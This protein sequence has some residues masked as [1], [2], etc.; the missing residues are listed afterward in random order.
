MPLPRSSSGWKKW[1]AF[2]KQT[3]TRLFELEPAVAGAAVTCRAFCKR[4]DKGFEPLRIAESARI[5]A[6]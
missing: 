3:E 1:S 4:Q 6:F 5:G 2:D